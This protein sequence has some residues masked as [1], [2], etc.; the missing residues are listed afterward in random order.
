MNVHSTA[1]CES[2]DIGEGTTIGAFSRIGA[3]ARVG[4]GCEI[5][6]Y[7]VIEA[8]GAIGDRV[9]LGAGV[10]VWRDVAIE[11]DARVA[12]DVAFAVS[13][14]T[15]ARIAVH[16]GARVGANATIAV[17]VTIGAG[18]IVEAGTVVTKSVP[19][20]AIVRGNPAR[21]VGYVDLIRGDAPLLQPA[22]RQSVT[23]TDV[24][25]VTLHELLLV[26]DMRGDLSAAEFEREVPFAARRYFIVFDVS[27]EEVRGEHAHRR[28]QQFLVCVRG[29]CRAIVD[30][31]RTR[32]EIVLDRPN[33]G[34]YLPPMVWGIQYQ[35]SADALLLV[36]ASEYYD[37]AD[38]IRDYGA[39]LDAVK[40]MKR[41]AR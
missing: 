30:D 41:A 21:I 6:D 36:F 13:S 12:G 40:A 1:L 17:G 3:K 10:R 28:C 11:D 27:N 26:H 19:P 33:L 39:F 15:G 9:S 5:G 18:A 37:P 2:T 23:P 14:A 16:R 4:Q 8:G 7:V 25:G 24:A 35:H 20:H 22:Q 32:A 38:Y 31:G 34:L 29:R